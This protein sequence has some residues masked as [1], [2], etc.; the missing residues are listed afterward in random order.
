MSLLITDKSPPHSPL[1]CKKEEILMRKRRLKHFVV[2]FEAVIRSICAMYWNPFC[3]LL[4]SLFCLHVCKRFLA[5]SFVLPSA[6]AKSIKVRYGCHRGR[7][8]FQLCN[9]GDLLERITIDF[10]Y[11]CKFILFMWKFSLFFKCTLYVFE[12]FKSN[13]RRSDSTGEESV[14][15]VRIRLYINIKRF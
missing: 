6:A 3:S 7:F 2:H 13:F 9:L 14:R 12:S 11:I 10:S 4:P 8:F 15:K 5:L 1:N